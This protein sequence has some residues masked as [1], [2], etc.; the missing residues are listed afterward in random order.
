M[1]GS[2]DDGGGWWMKMRDAAVMPHVSQGFPNRFDQSGSD[3][4]PCV[5]GLAPPNRLASS[6]S[7]SHINPLGAL[8]NSDSEHPTIGGQ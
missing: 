6:S 8:R 1:A 7:S 4:I 2:W 3:G 5:T